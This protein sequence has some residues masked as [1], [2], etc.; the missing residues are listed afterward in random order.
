[1]YMQKKRSASLEYKDVIICY[2]CHPQLTLCK[3]LICCLRV[4]A[5]QQTRCEED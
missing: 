1:M 5:S 2:S 4:E 3:D